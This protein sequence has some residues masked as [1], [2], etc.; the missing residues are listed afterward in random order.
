MKPEETWTWAEYAEAANARKCMILTLNKIK[1][2]WRK[3][4]S[5][6]TATVKILIGIFA[7][8]SVFADW[9]CDLKGQ[10]FLINVSSTTS[11]L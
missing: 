6:F 2:W 5:I 4:S 11:E 1:G 9:D 8:T 3:A 10:Y 7:G